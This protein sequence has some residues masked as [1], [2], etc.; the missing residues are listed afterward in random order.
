MALLSSDPRFFRYEG[1]KGI[2]SIYDYFRKQTPET[3]G[4]GMTKDILQEV[5]EKSDYSTK[6]KLA[7]NRFYFG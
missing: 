6:A 5:I 3:L 4:R 1:F 2:V 7:H